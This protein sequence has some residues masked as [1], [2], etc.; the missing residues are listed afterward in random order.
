MERTLSIPFIV[1]GAKPA[2][3]GGEDET[4]EEIHRPLPK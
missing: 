4:P 3:K 2:P 1:L